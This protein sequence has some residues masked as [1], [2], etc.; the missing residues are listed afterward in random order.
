MSKSRSLLIGI[1]I[2]AA[3]VIGFL[4]GLSVDSPRLSK[5]SVS[6]TIGKVNNYR[7]S[8]I[9]EAD[10]RLKNELASDTAK[11]KMLQG[12]FNFYYV[13]ALKM[14]ADV[15]L[16][17][18]EATSV[19]AFQ[20]SNKSLT[21][22][23]ENYGK[24]LLSARTD[25]LIALAACKSLRETDPILLRN[26]L[27]QGRNVVAQINYRDRVVLDFVDALSTFIKSNK[28][29]QFQGLE[30]AHDLLVAN[31]VFNALITKNKVVLK[32][33]DKTSLFSKSQENLNIWD[34]QK[35][36]SMIQ[37]DMEKLHGLKFNDAERLGQYNDADKLKANDAEKLGREHQKDAEKLGLS[38]DATKLGQIA[39]DAEKLGI[40][41]M[42]D[43]EKLRCDAE[44]L[45]ITD[46]EKLGGNGGNGGNWGGDTEKLGRALINDAEKLGFNDM[47]ML[48]HGVMR[49]LNDNESL[50]AFS[51][52]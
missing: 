44:K 42:A 30:K 4:I 52:R 14:T 27:N 2:I 25:L 18:K 16:A 31:E 38:K 34:Q 36:S 7:N 19:E 23:L 21:S 13:G 33:L 32:F 11:L 15:E 6:G 46:M 17:V 51:P 35:L 47:E 3:L 12:Y 37:Q 50:G 20:I 48:G 1:G 22:S 29:G 41:Y 9:S 10:I 39:S 8:Q 5:R 24:F 49:W 45:G 28:P 43:N 26:T 40:V